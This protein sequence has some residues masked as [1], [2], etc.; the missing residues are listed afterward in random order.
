MNPTF[1]SDRRVLRAPLPAIDVGAVV[2]EEIV[3]EDTVPAV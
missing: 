2:E 3:I 1:S